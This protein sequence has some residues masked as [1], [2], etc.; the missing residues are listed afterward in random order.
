MFTF[1][2]IVQF[3]I[4]Q[5]TV[6]SLVIND[7]TI[8]DITALEIGNLGENIAVRRAFYIRAASEKQLIAS[9][10]HSTGVSYCVL[11]IVCIAVH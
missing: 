6:G 3:G 4:D 11:S 7:K 1:G 10:V 8:A 5:Q 9:Y 2:C